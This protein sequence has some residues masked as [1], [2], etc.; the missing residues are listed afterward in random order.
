MSSVVSDSDW[1]SDTA[2]ERFSVH[3]RQRHNFRSDILAKMVA[4]RVGVGRGS[5]HG[6]TASFGTGCI[7][8]VDNPQQKPAFLHYIFF[9]SINE[10]IINFWKIPKYVYEIMEAEIFLPP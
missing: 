1:A 8:C 10:I 5:L 9:S 3:T 6:V 4:R 7:A 2:I